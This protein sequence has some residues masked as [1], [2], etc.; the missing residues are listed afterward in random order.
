ML[1]KILLAVII[2]GVAAVAILGYGTYK[3]ADETLKEQEPKLRH[4]IQLDEAA[5]NKYLVENIDELLTKV[6]LDNDGKPEKKEQIAKLKKL[7]T[8]PE[9]QSALIDLGR[10]FMAVGITVSD[11]IV[12]DL[13]ADDKAKYQKEADEFKA[14]AQKYS[15]LVE[16]ADPSFKN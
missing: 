9:I 13:S 15:E 5:Q 3:V 6:D 10:S 11:P 4:Y 1:K 12:K 7:N 2:I 8:Q 14:R 16:A